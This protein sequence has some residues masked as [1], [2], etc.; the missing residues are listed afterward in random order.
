MKV[1]GKYTRTEDREVL[2]AAYSYATNF[3]EKTP[4]LPYKA[5]D[6]ILAQTAETDPKA[7]GRKAEEFIDPTFYNE[8]ERSGFFKSLGL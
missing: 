2:A 7:K 1:I 8:L 5:I 3:V 6:M 4:R